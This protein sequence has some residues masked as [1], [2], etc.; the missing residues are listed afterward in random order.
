[1]KSVNK[2][3]S[4]LT[5]MKC[6]R[7]D[8]RTTDRHTNR[9]PTLLHNTPPLMCGGVQKNTVPTQSFLYLCWFLVWHISF[10]KTTFA[11]KFSV[12]CLCTSCIAKVSVC[13]ASLHKGSPTSILHIPISYHFFQYSIVLN[14]ED[15]GYSIFF[16]LVCCQ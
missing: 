6:G 4:Y 2:Y 3:L 13:A 16:I 5:E 14:H 9:W 10:C 15:A 12:C 8:G 7:M 1:M 11:Q